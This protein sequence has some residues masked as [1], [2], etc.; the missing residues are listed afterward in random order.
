M[1]GAPDNII[2]LISY[3]GHRIEKR[4]I[5]VC[6]YHI[7]GKKL[8]YL[9]AAK[10]HHLRDFEFRYVSLEAV[11]SWHSYLTCEAS[12]PLFPSSNIQDSNMTRGL[13]MSLRS[14]N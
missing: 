10:P 6:V 1:S 8:I 4:H 12:T 13:Y 5:L 3:A 14:L 11:D 9:Q 2:P 7:F